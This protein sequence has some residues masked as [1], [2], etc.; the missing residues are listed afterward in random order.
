MSAAIPPV[1]LTPEDV[2]RASNRDAKRYEL[3]DGELKEKVVGTEALYIALLIAQHFNAT[4]APAEGYAFVEAMIYCFPQSG[5]GRKPDVSF[6]WKRRLPGEKI[7]KGDLFLA[8]DVAIEVLSPG[9]TAT[10]MDEKLEDYLAAGAGMV[11]IVH[12]G[13]RSIR[14]FRSDGTTAL[15]QHDQLIENE[16]LLPRFRMAVDSVFPQ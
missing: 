15:V 9:N 8:P 10:E 4:Y 12:P 13:R 3:I 7:P 16:P 5:R 11:W 1:R 2:E 14:L 6:F